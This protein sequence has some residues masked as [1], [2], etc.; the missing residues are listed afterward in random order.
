[1]IY[2]NQFIDD[3]LAKGFENILQSIMDTF[4]LTLGEVTI[5]F[6]VLPRTAYSVIGEIL[7]SVYL[8]VGT[9][10]LV[11]ILI[12]MMDNTQEDTNDMPNEW[13]RQVERRKK[14]IFF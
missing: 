5:D 2:C 10:L 3:V 4:I 7:F 14:N 11:N 1:M 13:I 12:A 8:I 6:E 9:V